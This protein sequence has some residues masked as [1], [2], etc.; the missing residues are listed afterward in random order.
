MA[1]KWITGIQAFVNFSMNVVVQTDGQEIITLDKAYIPGMKM[2]LVFVLGKE[3]ILGTYEEVDEYHIQFP[4]NYLKSGDEIDIYF[5]PSAVSLGDIRVEASL[6]SLN[7][8]SNPVFNEVALVVETKSFYIYNGSEWKTF[9]IPFMTK[10]IGTLY[11]YE[12]Q[13]IT[14]IEN[15]DF[16]LDL[17]TYSPGSNNLCV[18][19]NGHKVD[20][21]TYVETG[22]NTLTFNST[23]PADSS[24]IE[25][26]V[27]IT[28]TWEE[29]N[30]HSMEFIRDSV[31]RCIIEYTK[32]GNDIVKTI[33]YTYDEITGYITQEVQTA[34]TKTITRTYTY[35]GYGNITNKTVVIL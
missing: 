3:H 9:T 28:D 32:V 4:P 1:L 6:T 26:I 35:D 33:E 27:W 24:Y 12:K 22:V 14:N 7:N 31:G 15:L 2:L 23:L 13:L 5:I 29:S 25:F 34:N 10:N 17:I 21:S 19:I 8:A 18:F 30:N 11:K 16:T 20:P